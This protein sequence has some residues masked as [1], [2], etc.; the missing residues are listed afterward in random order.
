MLLDPLPARERGALLP[1]LRRM[2]VGQFVGL[3][4]MRLVGAFLARRVAAAPS[5]QGVL[6]GHAG[7]VTPEESARWAATLDATGGL[8]TGFAAAG[9]VLAIGVL[10]PAV[11]YLATGRDEGG[12]VRQFAIAH[13]AFALVSYFVEGPPA[14]RRRELVASVMRRATSGMTPTEVDGVLA[15]ILPAPSMVAPQILGLT[16]L[17]V[18]LHLERTLGT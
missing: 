14:G 8:T 2:L 17:F 10:P 16:L 9:I 7:L 18:L 5:L 1:R 4:L 11:E 13:L 15:C 6:H 3:A 12:W